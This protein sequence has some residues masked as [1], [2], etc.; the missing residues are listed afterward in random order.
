MA[1]LASHADP[2]RGLKDDWTPTPLVV[3]HGTYIL[4]RL[5]DPTTFRLIADMADHPAH[6]DAAALAALLRHVVWSGMSNAECARHVLAA[7]RYGPSGPCQR[8]G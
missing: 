1:T 6:A 2:A 8:A 7:R 5:L 3:T 4:D